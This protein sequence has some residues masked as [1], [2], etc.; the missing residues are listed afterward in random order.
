MSRTLQNNNQ[1]L[2]QQQQQKQYP[3]SVSGLARS[4]RN[5]GNDISN[6]QNGAT[7]INAKQNQPCIQK[8]NKKVAAEAEVH[9]KPLATIAN[10]DGNRQDSAPDSTEIAVSNT[11]V[12]DNIDEREKN[13][14]LMAS[15]YA[16]DIYEHFRQSELTTSVKPT[17]MANQS[18]I[19]EHIRAI[20]IDWLVD[21]HSK[22]KLVPEALYLTV[23]LIDRYLEKTVVDRA[24]LQLVGVTCLSIA[25][26]YEEIYPP[27][28][29]ALVRICDNAYTR[30]D[31]LD[32]EK[33]ILETLEYRVTAPSAHA[34]LARYLKAAHAS[35]QM[36]HLACYLLDSSLQNYG[37]LQYLPSQLA[38]AA[39]MIARK[40][41]GRNL[42]SPTLSKF[43]EYDEEDI[44]PVAQA[45]LTAKASEAS[46]H[47]GALTAIRRKYDNAKRSKASSIALP[48]PG[49]I[50]S[51]S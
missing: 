49:D 2:M 34:F 21:V 36:I 14:P 5:F 41:C 11:E 28:L 43:A 42:W 20:L 9:P 7:T 22:F 12:I 4:G 8:K 16:Q 30:Q 26:K 35:K 27:E 31:I 51:S 45:L 3:A 10:H 24:T 32:M 17:Y 50:S 13:N 46:G 33:I 1:Q 23:N 15:D 6:M 44:V 18:H 25:S 37:L 29:C 39:V 40:L 48:T 38:S 19:N 47:G